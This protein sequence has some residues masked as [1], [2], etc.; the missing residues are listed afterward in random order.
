MFIIEAVACDGGRTGIH[1]AERWSK[2]SALLGNVN[3]VD[4]IDLLL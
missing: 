4:K 1:Y 3:R 2:Y